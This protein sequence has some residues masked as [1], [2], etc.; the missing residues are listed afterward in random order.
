[1]V[2]LEHYV[3]AVYPPRHV[4]LR[5]CDVP[6]YVLSPGEV[7]HIAGAL[8]GCAVTFEHAGIGD[9]AAC[10]SD[11]ASK[12]GVLRALHDASKNDA[13]KS[14]IGIVTGAWVAL[15]GSLLCAFVLDGKRSPRVATMM[16]VGILRGLS[17][18]HVHP[19]CP[20]ELPLPLEVS[21]CGVPARPGCGVVSGP[22]SSPSGPRMYK[23]MTL[24]NFT[25][26]ATPTSTHASTAPADDMVTALKGLTPKDRNLI[27]AALA[28]FDKKVADAESRAACLAVENASIAKAAEVDQAL[29]ASELERFIAA[30]G[31][32]RASMFGLADTGACARNLESP[33]ASVV[34]RQVDRLLTCCNAAMLGRASGAVSTPT[35]APR[36]TTPTSGEKRTADQMDT[37]EVDDPGSRLRAALSLIN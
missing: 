36:P 37:T 29:L 15:D 31:T 27:S 23:A 20:G 32:E 25:T 22:F 18:T 17:L 30:V 5:A 6:G 3:G 12:A 8:A 14:P 16:S 7:A 2:K 28:T 9:A 35:Y 24:H 34:R 33:N 4:V 13:L 11:L 1:M 19:S 26:M 21:L 10:V